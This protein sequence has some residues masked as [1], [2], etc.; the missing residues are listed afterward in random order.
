MKF[1]S[2]LGALAT[3]LLCSCGSTSSVQPASGNLTAEAGTYDSLVVRPF[4]D[5][6]TPDGFATWTAD[7]QQEHR[8]SVKR[9]GERIATLVISNTKSGSR[10]KSIGD[11]PGPGRNLLIDGEITGFSNGVAS[12]RLWVGMGAGSAYLDGV[13]NFK[14]QK[15]GKDIGRIVI[16]KNTWPLGGAIA[17][18]QN[19]DSFAEGAA[20]KIAAEALRFAR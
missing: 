4:R 2:A 8:A 20:E 14:D 9:A 17:A 5:S 10:F 7:E 12:L 15:T 19:A 6:T 18:S 11:K 16:D 1:I 13:A 3:L